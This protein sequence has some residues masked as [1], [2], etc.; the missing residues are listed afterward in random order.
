MKKLLLSFFMA[1]C[2]FAINAADNTITIL[3]EERYGS[4]TIS[5]IT[6]NGIEIEEDG[7]NI[8]FAQ[9]SSGN[10]P[11][12]NKAGDIRLYGGRSASAL[13]GNTMT[14]SIAQGLI[15]NISLGAANN[16][17]TWGV[18]SA[19]VGE[20]T[21]DSSHNA[22]WKGESESVTFTASRNSNNA[23]AST[24]NRYASITITY[25]VIET[26]CYTPEF[27]LK[28]ETYG[29]STPISLT[30]ATEG[31]DIMYSINGGNETLYEQPIV[32][33]ETGVYTVT[34]YAKKEGLENSETA[35]ATYSIVEF[36]G[37]EVPIVF[38]D[39]IS[40]GATVGNE[41]TKGFS[42]TFSQGTNS[43]N[44]PKCYDTTIRMYAGNT[45]TIKA[46]AGTVLQK[47]VFDIPSSNTATSSNIS[48][49]EGSFSL[50]E[51]TAIWSDLESN[52]AELTVKT[53]Q[54]HIEGLT[55]TY[56]KEAEE[57]QCAT[58]RFSLTEGDVKIPASLELTCSTDG[59]DIMYS[60]N[61]EAET[62]YEK[63]IEFQAAGKYT[64]TAY[65]KKEGLENSETVTAVYNVIDTRLNNLQEFIEQG[66]KDEST[67]FTWNFPVTVTA[68][69]E[70][71]IYVIDEAGTA[72]VLYDNGFK[73]D[74]EIVVGAKLA[75]GIQAKFK[76]Y[77]GLYE[78]VNW[79][80]TGIE[81]TAPAPGNFI[82]PIMEVAAVSEAD[83]NKVIFLADGELIGNQFTD[84]TGSITV[85]SKGWEAT[86]PEA[87]AHYDLLGAITIFDGALQI[88]PIEYF[89]VGTSGIENINA[90]AAVRAI[91]GAIE[92]A[93][94]GT[95]VVYNAAGQVVATVNGTATVN[96]PAG[97]YLVR[98][99][100]SV[101]K[102]LV[103]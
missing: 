92:I 12:Y 96:V 42:L 81:I 32:F 71:Y 73:G 62:L 45:L 26:H 39:F 88:Y 53:N 24:Q 8:T 84:A 19:N 63:P 57:T 56:A 82:Y 4:A 74:P 40:D 41:Y 72:I 76:N 16:D 44:A 36:N 22:E 47:I 21:E 85:F 55:I 77:R 67:V 20:L 61:G 66:I 50:S 58:P 90:A 75:A 27:S 87:G 10:A 59:A 54:F 51:P 79:D 102:V 37:G 99:A 23:S 48:V 38:S 35:T 1:I 13:D 83:M 17:K 93:G 2:A 98:T 49:S 103:K 9:G 95:S 43:N 18:L 31:A 100:D 68:A 15:K 52:T 64:V 33:P 97:F 6:K 5:N 14:V 28:S 101:A 7:I 94:E 91:D 69:Q 78:A 80:L 86:T 89:P 11:A 25:E 65:A 3:F 34:A 70:Q 30:C 46:P 60:I 29:L